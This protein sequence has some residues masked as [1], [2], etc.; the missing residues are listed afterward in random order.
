MNV[1]NVNS[2]FTYIPREIAISDIYI[3]PLMAAA[4]FA[5]FLTSLTVRLLN[6]LRWH[7]YFVCPP[8]VELALSVIYTV[9]IGTFLIPS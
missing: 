9:L 3:P 6:K 7:R 1:M 4:F 2:F 5:L 8:L